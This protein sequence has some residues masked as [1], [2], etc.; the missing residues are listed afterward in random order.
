MD[1][2]DMNNKTTLGRLVTIGATPEGRL[3]PTEIECFYFEDEFLVF[4]MT[5]GLSK[6]PLHRFGS[7]SKTDIFQHVT[8]EINEELTR[9]MLQTDALLTEMPE[10]ARFHVTYNPRCSFLVKKNK[11]E[12]TW[13]VKTD[14]HHTESFG[15][16]ETYEKPVVN[17][18]RWTV[19]GSVFPVNLEAKKHFLKF[20]LLGN[21]IE[22][23][24]K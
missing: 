5:Y 10:E 7:M 11:K 24:L 23:E 4:Q 12:N 19:K 9:H 14:G 22:K 3:A 17:D 20:D 16:L 2:N 1:I 6:V 13:E 21:P 15:E 8:F 18:W